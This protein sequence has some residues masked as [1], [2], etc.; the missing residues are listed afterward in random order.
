[1]R[2]PAL[3]QNHK[4]STLEIITKLDPLKRD[5]ASTNAISFILRKAWQFEPYE[6]GA[7]KDSFELNFEQ[8]LDVCE[9]LEHIDQDS[10]IYNVIRQVVDSVFWRPNKPNFTQQQ[11][12]D[13]SSKA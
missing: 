4:S 6:S 12:V 3:Y 1:M 2:A 5:E 8:A 7:L 11:R 9:L 10:A 13:L